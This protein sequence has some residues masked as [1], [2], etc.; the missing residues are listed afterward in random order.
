MTRSDDNAQFVNAARQ[1]G[2]LTE[3]IACEVLAASGENDPAST[4]VMTR[5]LMDAR[6]V[7]MIRML[8]NGRDVL[9]GY[10]ILG[11]IGH[12]GMGVVF[13]ARQETLE[14]EVALKTILV[15][16]RVND[17]IRRFRKEVTSIARLNHP[18]IVTAFDSGQHDGRVYLSMEL[19]EGQ[20]LT[21]YVRSCGRLPVKEALAITR[22]AAVGLAHAWEHGIVHRDIKPDNLLL[23]DPSG[24]DQE[25]T[26]KIADLGLAHLNAETDE[27]RITQAGAAVGTPL[28][29]APEQLSDG[30]VDCRSD[31]YSLGSTLYFMLSGGPPFTGDSVAAV[32]YN[33]AAGRVA[34][35]SEIADVDDDIEQLVKAMMAN[36]RSQRPSDYQQLVATIDRLAGATPM[37]GA[38]SARGKE[39]LPADADPSAVT[40]IGQIETP[41]VPASPSW[42]EFRPLKGLVAGV[43][44]VIAV[45]GVWFVWPSGLA[46]RPTAAE[47]PMTATWRKP[48]FNGSS[49]DDWD[50]HT[51][52]VI[53]EVAEDPV[54][55][56][57][58][59]AGTA[60]EGAS[61]TT[62]RRI[63][64]SD[65]SPFF[66]ITFATLLDSASASGIQFG[67]T[68]S[69][70]GYL[71]RIGRSKAELIE[72]DT[73]AVIDQAVWSP[74]R[75]RPLHHVRIRL[76]PTG[77]FVEV[78]EQHSVTAP[79]TRG[80]LREVRLFVEG[81]RAFFNDIAVTGLEIPAP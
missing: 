61:G 42:S 69:T 67:M 30:A 39:P 63:P 59:V 1:Q 3:Q 19:V 44:A 2:L 22:Q 36:E 31:I 9:P 5:G 77:W 43:I 6:Q 73:Q 71:L 15:G 75:S 14:R 62:S 28:Y 52:G 45:T 58:A 53:W 13:R 25:R 79:G 23:T 48:L 57:I 60:K 41:D 51:P 47:L 29:M 33:K 32:L 11:I 66:E 38:M 80:M 64:A 56:A 4:V 46:E 16:E 34:S 70:G 27:T 68:E 54:E 65:G 7:D 55:H 17:S 37:T 81:G 21:D 12:G 50:A 20:N 18:N 8:L 40:F 74:E 76:Q 49:L 26:V 24:I 72:Q 78:D 10:T 35:L